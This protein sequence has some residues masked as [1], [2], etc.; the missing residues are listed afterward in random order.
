MNNDLL[1]PEEL[2]KKTNNAKPKTK[3]DK[4]FNRRNMSVLTDHYKKLVDQEADN[5]MD[6][7]EELIT[8]KRADHE[9]PDELKQLVHL[10]I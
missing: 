6:E 5:I 9:L 4:M 1:D 8:L 10:Y 2:G 7:E 3:L